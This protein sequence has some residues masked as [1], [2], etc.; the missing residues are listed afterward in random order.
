MSEYIKAV[1]VGIIGK[2]VTCEAEIYTDLQEM[3]DISNISNI[4][5]TKG[6]L[7]AQKTEMFEHA[8]LFTIVL[9]KPIKIEKGSY[10]SVV[11]KVSNSAGNAVVRLTQESNLTYLN[12]DYW[13][14]SAYAARIKAFT[15]CEENGGTCEPTEHKWD[16]GV[17]TKEAGCEAEGNRL[18]TCTRCGQ[19]KNEVIA[20]TGHKWDKWEIT[21]NPTQ[22]KTGTAVRVCRNDNIHKEN[23]ILPVLS[24]TTVWT[25]GDCAA[26]TEKQD[27]WQ[28]YLSEYGT[29]KLVL[30]WIPP[31]EFSA[32]YTD[33]G[34]VLVTAPRPGAYYMI[35]AAYEGGRVNDVKIVCV[36]FREAGKQFISP[37][38]G[39]G[40]DN[41]GTAC[42]FFWNTF[43]DMLPLCPDI[44]FM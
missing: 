10:F 27:G 4:T 2:N 28:E 7:A 6:T 12:K 14:K 35:F 25:A 33:D 20:A 36:T 19:T 24:D 18:Y 22:T 39:F 23:H 44:S 9:D 42:V 15:V 16:S 38:D 26:P 43:S 11:I 21:V 32:R 41:T 1:N 5:P 34:N 30:P 17:V 29:V 8:G 13:Y 3:Q 31:T 40:A 37:P